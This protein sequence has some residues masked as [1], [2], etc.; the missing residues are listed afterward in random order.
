MN[1]LTR[2]VVQIGTQQSVVMADIHPVDEIIIFH[3]CPL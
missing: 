1:L 3:G 2:F